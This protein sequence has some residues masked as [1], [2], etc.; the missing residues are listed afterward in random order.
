MILETEESQIQ[1]IQEKLS[2]DLEKLKNKQTDEQDNNWNEKYT[3][4]NP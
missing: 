3:R 1:K 4:G 2:K